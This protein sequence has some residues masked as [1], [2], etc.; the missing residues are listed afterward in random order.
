MIHIPEFWDKF[1]SLR[2]YANEGSEAA[3]HF[4][5]VVQKIRSSLGNLNYPPAYHV[6]TYQV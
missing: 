1:G 4:H 3:N 6:M 5:N 2:N